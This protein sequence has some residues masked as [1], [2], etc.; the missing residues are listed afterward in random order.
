MEKQKRIRYIQCSKCGATW[1]TRSA[2]KWVPC[3]NCS[4]KTK[5]EE[6]TKMNEMR[7]TKQ[8]EVVLGEY[9]KQQVKQKLDE[10]KRFAQDII[11]EV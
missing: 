4:Y 1:K 10:K 2:M 8:N 6:D 11:D 7:A 5:N 3:P 9:L